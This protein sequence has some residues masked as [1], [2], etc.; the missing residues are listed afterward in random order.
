[1]FAAFL[2]GLWISVKASEN[3]MIVMKT[4]NRAEIKE[5]PD[6]NA[7]IILE[8]AQDT[9]LLVIGDTDTGWYH[10][11]YQDVKGYLGKED[12]IPYADKETLGQ[13]FAALE[14]DFQGSFAQVQQYQKKKQQDRIW[15]FIIVVMAAAIVA[16]GIY[17]LVMRNKKEKGGKTDAD[18]CDILAGS[19]GKE[20]SAEDRVYRREQ[21]HDICGVQGAGVEDSD[22]V[23]S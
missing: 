13:E 4:A 21:E 14:Q 18:Q 1:M 7:E 17:A 11:Q 2:C 20:R 9:P 10:V 5:S 15:R 12:I 8:V 3:T 22:S 19:N 16:L 6:E 23:G